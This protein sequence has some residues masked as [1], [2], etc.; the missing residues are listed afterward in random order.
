[1]RRI[2]R[3]IPRSPSVAGS[4]TRVDVVE[5]GLINCVELSANGLL[6]SCS[7]AASQDSMVAMFSALVHWFEGS[8]VRNHPEKSAGGA[9]SAP[10]SNEEGMEL[11]QPVMEAAAA[12]FAAKNPVARRAGIR[13]G[14]RNLSRG[15]VIRVND[16][17]AQM[18]RCRVV[19]I[20][21]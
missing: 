18:G 2:A 14:F 9:F 4:G 19:L 1:M 17:M 21:L 16:R 13:T 7:A 8:N 15:V 12:E 11:V 5:S 3:A 20:P 6:P 10:S